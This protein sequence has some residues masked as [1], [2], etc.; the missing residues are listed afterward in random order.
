MRRAGRIY[1]V[2]STDRIGEAIGLR[3]MLS[4]DEI[5]ADVVEHTPGR[6]PTAVE[7]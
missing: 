5:I 7:S 2:G 3:P 4:L 6:T 1:K